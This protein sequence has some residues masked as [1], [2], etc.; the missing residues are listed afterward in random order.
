MQIGIVTTWYGRGAAYVSRLYAKALEQAGH[1][2]FIFAREGEYL[3]GD[4]VWDGPRVHW[5]RTWPLTDSTHMQASDFRA[6]LRKNRIQA[7][8][9]NEQRM[10]WPLVIC[11]ELGVRAVAYVDYYRDIS[12]RLFAHFDGLIC[13]T[14]RHYSV[15][16]WHPGALYLPWGTD[17][18]VFAPQ[19]NLD[20][21]VSPN[22]MTF[23][24]SA[25]CSPRKGVDLLLQAFEKVTGPA[26]LIIHAQRDIRT[27][28]PKLGRLIDSLIASG[29]LQII[30]QTVTAPGLYHLG[31]V[32]VYPT[33]LEGIG[34]SICE[35][36]SCGLPAL[37][38]DN[39]PMNEFVEEGETG[40]LIPIREYRGRWDGY[41]WPLSVVSIPALTQAMQDCVDN[42]SWVLKAKR[43]ARESMLKTRDWNQNS[44]P[45]SAYFE[46]LPEHHKPLPRKMATK[47]SRY[48]RALRH[49]SD[50]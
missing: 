33:Y 42:P 46:T 21:L 31:D 2:V 26:K 30:N 37:V 25:G 7:V 45:L 23:F 49:L 4:P 5:A 22:E 29:R 44:L 39:G 12:V 28:H 20:A 24:H 6:W 1:T 3:K 38:P 8:L 32:Y 19:K 11:Q 18:A 47:F 14:A 9:F 41:Y 13:N 43:A 10:I 16:N 27:W 48:Y 17:T 36:L 15:F 34:L 50:I 40:R 35:A